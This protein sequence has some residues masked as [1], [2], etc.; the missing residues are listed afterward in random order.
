MTMCGE[1]IAEQLDVEGVVFDS[2]DLGQTL[3]T[4]DFFLTQIGDVNSHDK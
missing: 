1:E 2:Q 3:L 4:P